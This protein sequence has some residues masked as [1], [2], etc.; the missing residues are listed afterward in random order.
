[1]TFA[2]TGAGKT[3]GPVI[4]NALTHEGQLIVIDI[5]GEIHAATAEARRKMGQEV[6]VLDLRD[7]DPLPGSLNPFDLIS[8]SGTDHAAV[9]RS[10]AAELI[11]RDPSER[12]KFWDDWSETMI[13]GAATWLLADKPPEERCLSALFDLHTREDVTYK[14]AMMMD[15]K[16]RVRHRAARAAFSAYIGLPSENTRPSVL[17]TIVS[18]LRFLDSDMILRLTDTSSMDVAAL[19]AGEPMSLYIIVPPQRLSAYRPMLRVWLSTLILAMT[20]RPKPLDF[21][22]NIGKAAILRRRQACALNLYKV[23][24][25]RD[26]LSN[27]RRCRWLS[28]APCPA[29]CRPEHWPDLFSGHPGIPATMKDRF[30][31]AGE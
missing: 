29:S 13:A 22:G 18:H 10:F 25:H 1:M 9:G 11:V 19:I 12:P 27:P 23:T 26:P 31:A 8:L 3:T 5:K 30:H 16:E 28:A 15:D 21:R 4:C 24:H 20:Q 17:G 14:L 7:N 2:P 6:H